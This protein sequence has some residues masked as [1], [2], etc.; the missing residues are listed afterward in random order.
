MKKKVG[1]IFG[2]KSVEHEVSI[3]TGSQV[4]ENIDTNKYEIVPIYL[5][6]DGVWYSDKKLFNIDIYKNFDKIKTK[7]K[8]FIP[9]LN[10]KD[11]K[12]ILNTL[13]V[14]VI[15]SHGTYGEDGKLQGLLDFLD[16]P[17]TSS[18]VVGAAVGMDKIIMKKVFLGM[19]LP[20]LPYLWFTRDDW[21]SDQQEWIKKVHYTLDY[22][23]FVKPAN[24]GS[25]IGISMAKNEKELINAVNIAIRYDSRILIEKG[26]QKAIEVNCSALKKDKKVILSEL[27][28][29]MRWEEFLSFE[30]KYI[31]GNNKAKAGMGS[32]ARKIP[33][34]ISDEL[35]TKIE[36]Y[37]KSVYMAMHCK[38]VVR[39]DYILD[40]EKTKVHIN[41][42]NTIPGSFAF[43][44][45]EPKGIS[46]SQIL[47]II[48]NEAI[49]EFNNNKENVLE[50]D[51][52]LLEKLAKSQGTKT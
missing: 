4:L 30:D 37:S 46:F 22:P 43:Y 34:E 21:E 39:I 9:T 52:K 27:E 18:G 11:K 16:I 8:T 50:F 15:A 1:V 40:N 51:S 17:Y 23:V 44:L 24:L 33:A 7:I 26:M 28:E 25:S 3:I 32:M 36:D 19:S 5:G 2:G 45:W 41:E 48:I 47:D 42:I 20:V 49:K 14:I 29:P 38:G 12:N 6:K 13:D 10:K 31:R 35:K